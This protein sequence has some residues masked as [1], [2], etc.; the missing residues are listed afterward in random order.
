LSE[1]LY[2]SR[3]FET[4]PN[5]FSRLQVVLDDQGHPVDFIFLQ[6]NA[7]F[8]RMT[9]LKREKILGRKVTE[10]L[11]GTE[12]SEFDWIG[13]MGRVAQDG[14]SLKFEQYSEPL[15][16]WYDVQT[17]SD[18]AGH[19]TTVFNETTS[20]RDQLASMRSLIELSE[21]L[22]G[23]DQAAIDYQVTIDSLLRLSGAKFAASNTYEEGR[24]KTVT[25]AVAVVPAMIKQVSETLGFEINGQAWDILPERRVG[26]NID[27]T[28]IKQMEEEL[29]DRS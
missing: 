26:T 12:K 20:R 18:E 29:A 16:R 8:E 24:T 1:P 28:H 3:V 10:V 15:G 5:G 9:G 21:K 19:F 7:A 22:I 23:T 14:G 17:Y 27:L 6:V 11:P 4:L 13:V 25:R 2:Y